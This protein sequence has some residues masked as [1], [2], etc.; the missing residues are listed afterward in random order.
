MLQRILVFGAENLSQIAVLVFFGAT[1]VLAFIALRERGRS[2]RELIRQVHTRVDAEIERLN[3][4]TLRTQ[5]EARQQLAAL[6]EGKAAAQEEVGRLQ[7]QIV[8][9]KEEVASL[10]AEART[11]RLK[12]TQMVSG[13][14]MEW[15]SPEALLRLARQADDWNKAAGYLARINVDAATSRN[16]ETAGN[17]CRDHGFVAKA[18]ELYR[19]AVAK[20]PENISA[21]AELLALSA[22]IHAPERNQSLGE[23][24]ELVADT[25]IEGNNGTQVQNRFIGA[26]TGLGRFRELADFCESQLKQPLSRNAQS[27]LHRSLGVLYED[28]GRTDDA[29][30]HCEAALRLVGDS[31]DVLSLYTRLLISARRY[32]D[33]YRNVVRAL[34]NDPTSARSYLALAEIQEKRLGREAARDLLKKAVQWADA[35]EM[36]AIEGHLRRLAALDELSEI[37]PGAQTQFVQV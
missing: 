14:E 31:P 5:E 7:E 3:S 4:D 15:A 26:M 19:E 20:D 17:L 24:Q 11:A 12:A 30:A 34:H 35:A 22:E 37:L 1:V 18:V 6:S 10:L 27:T 9:T 13:E 23:L 33:A 32:D 36:C 21:R 16:L 2:R 25:L 28:I 8:S 29:I